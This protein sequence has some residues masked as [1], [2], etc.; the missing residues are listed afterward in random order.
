MTE[1][2]KLSNSLIPDGDTWVSPTVPLRGCASIT[3]PG[4]WPGIHA[5]VCP[6]P[7]PRLVSPLSLESPLGVCFRGTQ[8]ATGAFWLSSC[9]W[10]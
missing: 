5:L 2:Y 3:L 6:P 1:G 7:L 10:C 9:Q 8:L 4:M